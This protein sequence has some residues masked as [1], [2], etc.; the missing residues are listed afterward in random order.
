MDIIKFITDNNISQIYISKSLYNFKLN[1]NIKS[2]TKNTLFYGI[3][4]KEDIDYIKKHKGEKWILWDLND[5][6]PNYKVRVKAVEE[7]IKLNIKDHLSFRNQTNSYLEKF[8][9]NYTK[10]NNNNIYNKIIYQLKNN[11]NTSN[12]LLLKENVVIHENLI[13][14][15]NTSDK[16]SNLVICII[17]C[18]KYLDK[19]N[20]IRDTWLKEA[21]KKNI[22]Y[23]FVIGHSDKS[24]IV[25]DILYVNSGDYYEDLPMK[26][27]ALI[28]FIYDNTDFKY[29]WK[30]DDDC[31]VNI[32]NINNIEFDK[33]NYYGKLIERSGNKNKFDKKW[34]FN[35]CHSKI[36]NKTPAIKGYICDWYGGG[37][38]Y[39]L[40]KNSM[41]IIIKNLNLF[42]NEIYEDKCIGEILFKNYIK[43]KSTNYK[44]SEYYNFNKLSD[45]FKKKFYVIIDLSPE[46]IRKLHKT[47]PF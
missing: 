28:K 33:H 41:K 38:G 12:E 24:V 39:F 27:Y 23:Y 17:T 11:N 4:Y 5:C 36:L 42:Y 31:Y 19:Q 6:N 26:M 8:K 14:K 40:S 16:L 18:R 9:I 46:L 22:N 3:Y 35:K 15:N 7:V 44:A 13:K 1:H 45:K 34:H 32:N 47:L 20:A 29:I 25:D 30:I 37:Y 21:K 2:N 43:P 10:I